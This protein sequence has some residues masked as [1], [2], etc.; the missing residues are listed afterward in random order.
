ML[1]HTGYLSV[2]GAH[3]GAVFIP[4]AELPQRTHE[5][6]PPHREILL[7]RDSQD[8]YHALGW[9]H[10]RGRR[11][12]L[13][14][15]PAHAHPN[16]RYRLWQPNAWLEEFIHSLG[17]S[18]SNGVSEPA[19]SALTP[20]PPLVSSA[21]SPTALDL[22]CGSGREAVYLADLG[23]QVTAVDR[24]PDALARGRDLQT[25]YAPDSLPIEWLCVDLEKSDWQPEEKYDLITLFYFY[26]RELIQRACA[27][28]NLGGVLLVEAFTQLHRAYY[29]KPASDLRIVRAG[30]LPKM[31][32][33]GM[34]I[35]HY[36]E[37]WRA[38]GRHT[39]RLM[40][41]SEHR[42]YPNP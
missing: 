23:W 39:A 13:A 17:I 2:S 35:V 19:F 16:A 14:D 25:R 41:L 18:L 24:L 8:A 29:G 42:G 31:L 1:L 12:R 34:C 27:W 22:G 9:L 20:Q 21:H 3:A 37:D 5:L 33:S 40:A 15:P 10:A 4:L 38:N 11:A 32:P 28:L 26:S 7:I 36:S 30:E 6:P